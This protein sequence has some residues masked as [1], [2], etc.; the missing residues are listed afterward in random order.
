MAKRG[1]DVHS[2]TDRL[3]IGGMI[4][5]F[6]P[7]GLVF[8]AKRFLEAAGAV[9]AQEDPL[10]AQGWHPVGK[11]LACHSIELSLKAFLALNGERLS[12]AK[13]FG[14]DLSSLLEKAKIQELEDVVAL[15]TEELNEIIKASPYYNEKV[16][17]YPSLSEAARAYPGDPTV[18]YLLNAAQKLVDGL[19]APC[20]AAA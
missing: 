11:Y 1:S 14:H 7:F 9:V 17:E 10:R 13:R 8:T 5:N 4:W 2:A 20:Q 18:S 3:Q 15:T 16:F 12:G 19:Y 6:A